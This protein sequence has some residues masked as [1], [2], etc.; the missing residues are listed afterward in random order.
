[1]ITIITL[2]LNFTEPGQG[3]SNLLHDRPATRAVTW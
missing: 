2:Q 1:M 3:Q